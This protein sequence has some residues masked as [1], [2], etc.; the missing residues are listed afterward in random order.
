MSNMPIY[1]AQNFSLAVLNFSLGFLEF[2]LGFFEE[3]KELLCKPFDF[4]IMIM[5]IDI[6]I[7]F[8]TL[9]LG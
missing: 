8:L 2:S 7:I 6:K 1:Q 5:N 9:Q 3:S 4:M